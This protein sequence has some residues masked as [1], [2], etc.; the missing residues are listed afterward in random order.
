MSFDKNKLKQTALGGI[1]QNPTFVLVLG[2]CPTIAASTSL[3]NALG[4]G[5]STMAVLTLSNIFVSLF[6]KIIPDKVRIPAYILIMATITTVIDL[7]MQKFLPSL[8]KSLGVFIPLIVVNCIIFARAEA[9]ASQNKVGYAALDGLSMGAGFT[10]SLSLLA[11]I[12]ELLAYGNIM[13]ASPAEDVISEARNTF[14]PI[15][16]TPVGGFI[17]LAVLLAAFSAVYKKI[18]QAQKGKAQRIGVIQPL[19]QDAAK[20]VAL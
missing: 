5:L 17:T 16:V 19:P 6:R 13:L 11:V 10:L 18:T 20:E 1:I 2:M 9:F 4:M 8:S 12:R 3:I 15:F 7:A 14:M